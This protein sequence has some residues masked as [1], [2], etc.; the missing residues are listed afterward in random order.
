LI[1][2]IA[3]E[4]YREYKSMERAIDI[5]EGESGSKLAHD[6]MNEA[7]L[8]G[9]DGWA[10]RFHSRVR[11]DLLGTFKCSS[12]ILK[13]GWTF[14][15]G[16]TSDQSLIGTTVWQSAPGVLAR[17]M[18]PPLVKTNGERPSCLLVA[19]QTAMLPLELWS[20]HSQ[21]EIGLCPR[22]KQTLR[23]VT[24]WGPLA[25]WVNMSIRGSTQ[26]RMQRKTIPWI[27]EDLNADTGSWIAR[28]ILI[29]RHQKPE[30]RGRYYNHSGFANMIITGLIGVHPAADDELT[31]HPMVSSQ[32]WR[33]FVLGEL[34]YHGHMLTIY[35]DHDGSRY[36]K[37]R[38]LRVLCDG[39]LVGASDRLA[40][41]TVSRSSRP[42]AFPESKASGLQKGAIPDG[43]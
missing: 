22:P 1:L 30:N 19:S 27:D 3:V 14:S 5:L 32:K 31:V 4:D 24:R 8:I 34:P 43:E 13:D 2:P 42:Y 21:A 20:A 33:Y 6:A 12:E 37:G 16:E 17:N 38:G 26:L 7:A 10:P 15:I 29:A 41:L 25:F 28:S 39:R 35:Y 40:K 18:E 23:L 36:H 11:K 9:L